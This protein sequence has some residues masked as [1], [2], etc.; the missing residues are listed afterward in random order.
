MIDMD[1]EK[2]SKY[3]IFLKAIPLLTGYLIL[4]GLLQGMFFYSFFDVRIIDYISLSETILLSINHP[5]FIIIGSSLLFFFSIQTEEK[6]STSKVVGSDKFKAPRLIYI[7]GGISFLTAVITAIQ[8]NRIL[9]WVTI[10]SMTIMIIITI[11]IINYIRKIK[12]TEN[13][14]SYI[15]KAVAILLFFITLVN[16]FMSSHEAVSIKYGPSKTRAIITLKDKE[17][18][19]TS[20]SLVFVGKVEKFTFL[21][22]KTLEGAEI[23]SNDEIVSVKFSKNKK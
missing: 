9:A 10:G 5:L 21:Y 3:D 1:I 11:Y 14:N 18:V 16:I 6:L 19:V 23:I 20:D 2:L 22:N 7:F 15:T 12:T 4:L 17:L 8:L 13:L